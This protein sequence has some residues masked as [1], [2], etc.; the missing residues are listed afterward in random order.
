MPMAPA[1]EAASPRIQQFRVLKKTPH[2]TAT[3]PWRS[4][5]M[6]ATGVAQSDEEDHTQHSARLPDG[7]L[8]RALAHE[9][10]P[11]SGFS[12]RVPLPK[13]PVQFTGY[14]QTCPQ[15]LT[16]LIILPIRIGEGRLNSRF[17]CSRRLKVLTQ[18]FDLDVCRLDDG[19]PGRD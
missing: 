18:L 8:I 9:S 1:S 3:L 15:A 2:R 10:T 4:D 11:V 17:R 5:A 7:H 12:I 13:Q 19:R 16:L 6:G 14:P